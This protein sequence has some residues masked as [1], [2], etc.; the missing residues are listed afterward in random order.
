M[1]RDCRF[2]IKDL[3]AQ[4]ETSAQSCFVQSEIDHLNSIIRL[5]AESAALPSYDQISD[6]DK[7]YAGDSIFSG[8]DSFCIVNSAY[9]IL[10]G[11]EKSKLRWQELPYD[12]LENS[13]QDLYRR[14]LDQEDFMV[15]CRMM[16]DLFKIQILIATLNY[17]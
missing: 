7:R 13:F 9:S 10:A 3:Q 8:M 16:L 1:E 11:A 6:H 4:M 17:D 15:R 12:R 5:I 14:F 2:E